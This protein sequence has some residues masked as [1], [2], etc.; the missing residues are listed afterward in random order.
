[1]SAFIARPRQA[2]GSGHDTL[3]YEVFG[4]N[5]KLFDDYL[6]LGVYGAIPN[7]QFTKMRAFFNDEREQYFSN[8]LHP[9]LYS[10]RMRALSLALGLGVKLTQRLS[11]GIGATLSLKANVVAPTYVV[12]AGKLDQ[13]LIDM[14]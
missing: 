6:A 12:D 14:N 7:G 13:I 3:T 8:S 2:A 9:E 10:D 5:V 4:L 1:H 11:L